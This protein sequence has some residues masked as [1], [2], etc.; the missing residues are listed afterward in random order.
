MENEIYN[1]VDPEKHEL[2][3]FLGASKFCALAWITSSCS[4]TTSAEVEIPVICYQLDFST[5]YG[6]LKGRIERIRRVLAN[7]R[8]LFSL[9]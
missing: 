2:P 8:M 6:V 3:Q 9:N 1:C 7:G 5:L 4:Y